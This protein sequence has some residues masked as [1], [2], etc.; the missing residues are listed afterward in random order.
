MQTTHSMRTLFRLLP[1]AACAALLCGCASS[2]RLG[3]TLDPGLRAVYVPTVLNEASEPDVARAVDRA[4]RKEIRR[5]GTLRMVPENEAETRLDVVVTDYKQSAVSY[6]QRDTQHPNE[7]KMTVSARV[8]FVRL[9]RPQAGR[10]AETA[11]WRRG[12]VS[13]SENFVGGPDSVAAKSACL[14]E[15]AKDLAV[16]IVDG[17][18]GAW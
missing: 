8:S 5:E 2:Y 7:Y 17:C 6:S 1:A 9:A 4:L 3:T 15:A 14:P 18:V 16:A 10:P 11:I 12:S 13:G